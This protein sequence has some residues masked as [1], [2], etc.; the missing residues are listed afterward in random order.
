MS[1]LISPSQQVEADNT[2]LCRIISGYQQRMWEIELE[3]SSEGYSGP[4]DKAAM[5]RWEESI[6]ILAAAKAQLLGG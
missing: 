6:R 3:R 5:N 4:G 1:A 2:L